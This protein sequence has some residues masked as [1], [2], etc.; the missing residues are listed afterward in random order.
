MWETKTGKVRNQNMDYWFF[1]DEN[2]THTRE[3]FELPTVQLE[4]GMYCNRVDIHLENYK[5]HG[6][7]KAPLSN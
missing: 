6:V 5:S 3:P 1:K 7:I 2:P 4:D